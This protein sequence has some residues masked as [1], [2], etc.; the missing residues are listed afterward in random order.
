M[1]NERLAQNGSFVYYFLG[2]YAL[3]TPCSRFIYCYGK[4]SRSTY[5]AALDKHRHQDRNGWCYWQINQEVLTYQ[6]IIA[7]ILTMGLVVLLGRRRSQSD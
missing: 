7:S 4:T 6:I 1:G 2:N 5:Y 3:D